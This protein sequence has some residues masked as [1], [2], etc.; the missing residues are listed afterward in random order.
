MKRLIPVYFLGA[1][2]AFAHGGHEEA[3]IH[4]DL[5]W[6]TSGDHVIVLALACF[7][8]GLAAR[9]VLRRLRA[10]LIRA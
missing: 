5:H 10:A 4:G 1:P 7:V 9:P 8:A 2:A 6:L 3:V